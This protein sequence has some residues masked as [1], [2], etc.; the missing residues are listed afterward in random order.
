MDPDD[1]AQTLD[2]VTEALTHLHRVARPPRSPGA[3]HVSVT[4]AMFAM[5]D[6]SDDRSGR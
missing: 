5:D 2:L 4:L 1:W 6:V 3:L